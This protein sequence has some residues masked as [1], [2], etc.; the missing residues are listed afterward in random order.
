MIIE[1]AQRPGQEF[2]L[3]PVIFEHGVDAFDIFDGGFSYHRGVLTIIG[4]E[5]KGFYT[6]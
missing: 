4:R 1:L 5:I 6:G 2:A 3:F